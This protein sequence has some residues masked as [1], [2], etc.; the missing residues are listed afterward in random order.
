VNGSSLGDA[1]CVN[2]KLHRVLTERVPRVEPLDGVQ[3]NNRSWLSPGTEIAGHDLA[4]L[5]RRL[6]LSG[7]DEPR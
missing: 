7:A 6:T 5:R 4:A 2:P 3:A 1:H